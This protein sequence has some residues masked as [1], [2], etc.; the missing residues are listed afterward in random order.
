[1]DWNVISAELRKP[2]DSRHVKP[3]KQYGPK[4]DYIEAF[5]SHIHYEPNSGCWLWSGADNGVG[6][7]KFRGRYAHRISWEMHKGPIP[8]GMHI[9]HL[10]RVRCCVNPEHLE[11]VTNRE[12]ARRGNT[13]I[14]MRAAPFLG[15]RHPRSKLTD[16]QAAEIKARV[17]AGEKH[18]ILAAEYGVC[19]GVVSHIK[20]GRRSA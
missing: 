6:Y 17:A 1:M 7:G 5:E 12:N 9:D 8:D 13:G 2:L 19:K 15:Q 11:P 18:S 10:C 16:A 14:H 4:G 20:T 3:A